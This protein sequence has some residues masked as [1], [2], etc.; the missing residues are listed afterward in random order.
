MLTQ[1]TLTVEKAERLCRYYYYAGFCGLPWLWVV[2]W[3]FFRHHVEHSES[4]RWYVIM[5]L[6][7]GIV[8][9]LAIVL[10]YAIP[11]FAL[12]SS[13]SLWV[14]APGIKKWQPGH[15]SVHP[16]DDDG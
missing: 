9:M 3:L 6:R 15:F 8:G 10:L 1:E 14:I 4:I 16:N 2:M 13:S 12:P 7:L 11:F 5:S